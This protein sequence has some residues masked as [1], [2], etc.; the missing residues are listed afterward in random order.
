M[1]NH[2]KDIFENADEVPRKGTW[3]SLGEQLPNGNYADGDAFFY[4]KGNDVVVTDINGNFV[5]I[6]KDGVTN[7]RYTGAKPAK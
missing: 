5:T 3:R 1:S 2:I 4:R 6:L 7:K